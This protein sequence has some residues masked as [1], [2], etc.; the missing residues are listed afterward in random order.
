M[1]RILLVLT[2]V[3]LFFSLVPPAFAAEEAASELSYVNILQGGG[4]DSYDFLTDGD[5]FTAHYIGGELIVK[6]MRGIG[7][8]YLV[9]DLS[10]EYRIRDLKSGASAVF[11]G[12]G[13]IHSVADLEQA[14]GYAP[15]QIGIE[16]LGGGFVC[17]MRT[18]S[19][20]TLPS[21]VQCWDEPLT[22]GADM[23]LF[24]THGDDEQL[25]FAGLLPYYAVERGLDVQVV[26]MTDHTNNAGSTRMHEMLD[27]L[28]AVGIRAYPVFGHFPDFKKDYKVDTYIE[29]EIMGITHEELLGYVVENIRRFKPQVAVGHDFNGE[30]GHG[31]H[32]VYAELLGEAVQISMDPQ[33]YPHQVDRYGTWDVPKTYIH[34][35]KE[36]QVWM[37]WDQP[38]DSFGGMTAFE[39]T[40]KL[41]FPS[42][43]S[44]QYEQYV[45]WLYGYDN[46][47]TQASQIRSWS[48]CLYGLY[49]STVGEDV[50]KNDLMENITPY[51]EQTRINEQRDEE[52]RETVQE[53]QKRNAVP[54]RL[55]R[56]P[57][58]TQPPPPMQEEKPGFPTAA[59]V[60]G[61]AAAAG[62]AVLWGIR[63]KF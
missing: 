17:E 9:M 47:I 55:L 27:G 53:A 13:F 21:W 25:Y 43:P 40:Q 62:A 54:T 22:G 46:S 18:F 32:K 23:V 30:Y 20:G 49:R 42:H 1:R 33:A 52:L 44:Q 3:F 2:A 56:E 37:D 57:D 29:Y 61:T 14:F 24:S 15:R 5:T 58:M 34:L 16:F 36:N 26:Y 60:L 7:S 59:A 63:K 4:V 28:W 12:N 39:V 6:N 8:V 11:G 51:A 48:P 41:G 10:C 38:L 35:Y 50:E 19:P 45:Y 31:M